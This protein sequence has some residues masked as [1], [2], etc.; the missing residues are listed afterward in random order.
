MSKNPKTVKQ[1]KTSKKLVAKLGCRKPMYLYDR[2]K[3]L[4]FL[5]ISILV[6]AWSKQT[7]NPLRVLLKHSQLRYLVTF[8][9]LY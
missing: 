4:V 1:S 6:I 8:G 9:W 5:V 7:T 2:G 3:I